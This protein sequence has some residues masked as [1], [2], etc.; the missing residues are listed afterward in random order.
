LSH[1]KDLDLLLNDWG[2]HDLHISSNIEADGFVRRGGPVI[3]AIFKSDRAYFIDIMQHRDWA[4]EHIIR[5]ILENWPNDGLV[6]E[7][8]GVVGLSRSYSDDE[9][10]KIRAAGISTFVEIDGHVYMPALGITTAGTSTVVSMRA[11]RI[12]RA[13]KDFDQQMKGTPTKIIDIIREHGRGGH[14][15]AKTLA[16]SDASPAQSSG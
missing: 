1:R 15:S 6:N 4:R 3:F 2:I 14:L 12:L 8:K 10:A 16:S 7:I 9:R 5:V 11:M 13:L